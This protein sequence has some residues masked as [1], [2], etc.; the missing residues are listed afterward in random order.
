MDKF[1]N[2]INGELKNGIVLRSR[3][4]FRTV[5]V[6]LITVPAMRSFSIIG[7]RGAKGHEP[8]NTLRSVSRAL[9]FGADGVEIDVYFVD[10][11]LVVIH[12]ETLERT[13]NGT[14]RVEERSFDYLRSLD[15]G[16]GERIPTLR[17]IFERVNRR[18]FLNIELKGVRTAEP[19]SDLIREYLSERNWKND[20]FI[21]SSFDLLELGRLASCGIRLGLLFKEA[22]GDYHKIAGS[23]GAYSVHVAL[24][25]V[26][27]SFVDD[28]HGCG[29]KV[30]V[31]TVNSA[32]DIR[33]MR[34]LGVD[35]V[36]TDYPDRAA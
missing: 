20:D 10:G 2:A 25:S 7:H 13:T 27:Q 32:A 35:G 28:A 4:F 30:L 24:H 21:V 36:F 6:S 29:L 1:L 34:E 8:E 31:Y 12:D 9:D 22:P 17:E 19:V 16:A 33:R 15:A 23:L 26:S 11:Q 3:K 5:P 18:A 14:G